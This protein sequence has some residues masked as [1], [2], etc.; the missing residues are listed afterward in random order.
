MHFWILLF[1]KK[2]NI[3]QRPRQKKT[4]MQTS[5]L[6]YFGLILRLLRVFRYLFSCEWINFLLLVCYDL[7][8]FC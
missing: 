5:E 6:L 8:L 4:A 3:K 1:R 2:N 7:G